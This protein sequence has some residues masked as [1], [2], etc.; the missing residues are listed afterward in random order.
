MCSGPIREFLVWLTER[1]TLILTHIYV[2]NRETEFCFTCTAN[3]AGKLVVS[4]LIHKP[5][6][7][8]YALVLRVV[9]ICSFLFSLK[10]QEGISSAVKAS[11]YH[12]DADNHK[13]VGSKNRT[14]DQHFMVSKRSPNKHH[15]AHFILKKEHRIFSP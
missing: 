1:K 5:R 11:E 4:W 2:K 12:L 7:H 13:S 9:V 6:K 10:H 8:E 15:F 14:V 3:V